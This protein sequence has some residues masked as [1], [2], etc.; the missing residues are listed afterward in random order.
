MATMNPWD[1]PV[2]IYRWRDGRTLIR[3]DELGTDDQGW[4]SR[5]YMP[6]GVVLVDGVTSEFDLARQPRPP[7]GAYLAGG[8]SA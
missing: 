2:V 8:T 7:R 5:T 1:A 3:R 6:H 4:V